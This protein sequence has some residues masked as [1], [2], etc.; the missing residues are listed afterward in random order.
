MESVHAAQAASFEFFCA[1]RDGMVNL[2]PDRRARYNL[3]AP[4][5]IRILSQFKLE[6]F[7]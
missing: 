6:R 2:H 7:G 1:H 3:G 5:R 4:Y